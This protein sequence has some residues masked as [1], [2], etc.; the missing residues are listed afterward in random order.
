MKMRDNFVVH[1]ENTMVDQIELS[2][3]LNLYVDTKYDE[4]KHRVN[5]GEVAFTPYNYDTAI[6][7]GDTIYFHHLVVLNGGQKLPGYDDHYVVFYNPEAAINSQVIAY[8][9]KDSEMVVPMDGW[10]IL[11]HVEEPEK[12]LKSDLI[13]IV[14]L[15]KDDTPNKGEVAFSSAEAE[16]LGL[17]VGDVVG[18]PNN[19]DYRF[20]IDGEEYYRVRTEDLLYVEEKV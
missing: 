5:E 7:S 14:T 18:F 1:L 15:E 4:F 20:K 11:K 9:K 12:E 8:K 2:N 13:E 6:E 16:E 3:G 19:M 17:S 10:S